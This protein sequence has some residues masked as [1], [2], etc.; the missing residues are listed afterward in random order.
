MKEVDDGV[1]KGPPGGGERLRR[2]RLEDVTSRIAHSKDTY[3][4]LAEGTSPNREYEHLEQI[5]AGDSRWPLRNRHVRGTD[6]R[7]EPKPQGT[8]RFCEQL[9]RLVYSDR[10]NLSTREGQ[11]F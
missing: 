7:L 9:Q 3:S 10:T 4:S 2:T 6:T 1:T 8:R 5:F 11:K